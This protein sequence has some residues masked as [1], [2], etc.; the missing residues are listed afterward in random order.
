M[1]KRPV[2]TPITNQEIAY[3]LLVLAGTMTDKA[4]AKV[5]GIDPSRAAYVKGKPRVREY[6]AS[7]RAS[8]RAGLAQHEVDTLVEFNIGREQIL[9]KWWEFANID[10]A[11]TG[12][13]TTGQSKA[14]DSLWKALGFEGSKKPGDE[15]EPEPERPQ[16][17]RAK[18]MRRPG[19]PDYEEGDGETVGSRETSTRREPVM[20]DPQPPPEPTLRPAA[21][22]QS[23]AVRNAINRSAEPTEPSSLRPGA[24]FGRF[25]S[26]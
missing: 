21:V 10:P 6:M 24:G 3:A 1:P 20:S 11:K 26:T 8:V 2:Q 22:P 17:Y 19:D 7:H 16:I 25:Q 5:V 23:T 14:L 12:Y 15:D 4:A 13:N 9:G 18:W